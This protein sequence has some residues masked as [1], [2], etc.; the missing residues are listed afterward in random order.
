MV[1]YSRNA[2]AE[3]TADPQRE[4]AITSWRGWPTPSLT[5]DAQEQSWP[6]RYPAPC[7]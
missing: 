3:A 5:A 1:L 7:C 4:Q 6:Q 2:E